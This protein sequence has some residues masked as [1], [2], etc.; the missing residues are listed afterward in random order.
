MPNCVSLTTSE[1]V[2]EVNMRTCLT[3]I[4]CVLFIVKTAAACT[5]DTDCKGD[6]ICAVETGQEMGRCVAPEP[7]FVPSSSSIQPNSNEGETK[8][9]VSEQG[10]NALESKTLRT[11]HVN[12]LGLLQTGLAPTIEWGENSTFL[13]RARLMNSGALSYLIAAESGEDFL[14]GLG[15]SGQWRTYLGKGVQTGPYFGGGAE[16]MYTNSEDEYGVYETYY[17]VPQFEGGV[18][19]DSDGY[20]SAVGAFMG[21]ALPVS[22]GGYSD[23]EAESI[24][25]GGLSWDVGVHF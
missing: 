20:F 17:L 5:K 11:F 23:E 6:R 19:W 24:I 10:E 4:L 15:V 25:V 8:T 9:A 1:W 18:R 7:K 13:L 22:S 12:V 3:A 2:L 21:A 16:L 14:F